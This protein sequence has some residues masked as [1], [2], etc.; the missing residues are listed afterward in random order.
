MHAFVSVKSAGGSNCLW[1][2]IT[3]VR[4]FTSVSPHVYCYTVMCCK[5]TRTQTAHIRLTDSMSK[6][7]YLKKSACSKSLMTHITSKWFIMRDFV[8]GHKFTAS[9]SGEVQQW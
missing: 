6:H 1:A 8:F 4:P 5:P 3:L 7:V 9:F 2:N